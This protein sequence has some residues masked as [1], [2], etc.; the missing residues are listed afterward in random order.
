MLNESIPTASARTASSMVL[1]MTTSPVS[2]HPDPSTVTKTGVSNPNSISWLVIAHSF[3]REEGP[4]GVRGS[5]G[6]RL[7]RPAA[8]RRTAWSAFRFKQL[9]IEHDLHHVAKR[10][11]T[12]TRRHRDVDA[13]VLAA[14]LRRRFEPGVAGAAPAVLDARR[15]DGA[16]DRAVELAPPPVTTAPCTPP[17]GPA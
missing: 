4:G 7:G 14:D 8:V 17:L 13:E 2:G 11:G 1:R 12:D 3:L 16:H 5:R 9:E 10:D 6:L 15:P